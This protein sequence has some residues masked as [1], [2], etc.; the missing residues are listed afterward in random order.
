MTTALERK[1]KQ[2]AENNLA[3]VSARRDANDTGFGWLKIDEKGNLYRVDPKEITIVVLG[4]K[5]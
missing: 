3:M 5:E 1:L 2:F 4:A